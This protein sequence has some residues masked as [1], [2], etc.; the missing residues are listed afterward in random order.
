M[1]EL[2]VR[3]VHNCLEE[4]KEMINLVPKDTRI[5]LVGDLIDRGPNSKK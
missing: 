4:L 1:T 2:I 3:N 5:V